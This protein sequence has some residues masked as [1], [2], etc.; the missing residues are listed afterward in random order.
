MGDEIFDKL[1]EYDNKAKS[2]IPLLEQLDEAIKVFEELKKIRELVI[3]YRKDHVEDI[4]LTEIFDKI[5]KI[6]E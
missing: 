4:E 6:T 3:K 1:I 2:L 5:L